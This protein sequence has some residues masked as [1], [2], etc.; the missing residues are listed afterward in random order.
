MRVGLYLDLRNPPRWQQPSSELYARALRRVEH[1]EQLGIGSVWL[2]EH[3]LFEDGYLPQPMTFAAAIA[4]RTQTIRIGSAV[5]VAGL[6]PAIDVA[7]QGAI[8]DILSGGRLEL[9]LGAGYRDAEFAA[10]GADIDARY[11]MLEERAAEIRR[12]WTEGGATPRPVQ[13][14]VPIW[15]GGR[16]PRAARIAGRLGEGLL[17]LGG[18]L[19]E[20]YVQTLEIAGH[21]PEAARLAGLANLIL[22]DDPEA[23][24]AQIRPHLSYQWESYARYGAE[25][26][27]A[28]RSAAVARVSVGVDVD[29][30]RSKGPVM[31]PPHFDVTTPEDAAAR[32]RE[33]IGVLPVVDVF[34]WDSIAGMPDALVNRHIELL[35]TR[36]APAVAAWGHV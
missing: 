19:F 8:V 34:F 31:S 24:W 16:G 14:R 5:M 30:L 36:L 20:T 2:T 26:R 1:A 18:E 22:A 17:W 3:H 10:F 4:A 25:G 12:L 6:R 13:S 7:E 32:L 9:G 29:S 27:G 35:A 33:W 28:I 11:P 15:I 21:P 23:A